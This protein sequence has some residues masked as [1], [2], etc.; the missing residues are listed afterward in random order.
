MF[1][2]LSE[3]KL[4]W[5]NTESFIPLPQLCH[6]SIYIKA[7]NFGKT[8]SFISKLPNA[9]FFAVFGEFTASEESIQKLFTWQMNAFFKLTSSPSILRLVYPQQSKNK[10]RSES[11]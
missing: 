10:N 1:S 11:E 3:L 7:S 4:K 5:V 8:Y 6:N 2:S 9:L